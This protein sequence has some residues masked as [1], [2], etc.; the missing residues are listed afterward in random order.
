MSDPTKILIESVQ[1]LLEWMPTCSIGSSGHQRRVAVEE[2]IK[3]LEQAE[4]EN[5]TGFRK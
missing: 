2:A 5:P 1:Y 3:H 4:Q